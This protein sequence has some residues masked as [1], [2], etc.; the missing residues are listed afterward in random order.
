MYKLA[1]KQRRT[2]LLRN[3]GVR[4]YR[5]EH[6]EN[7]AISRGLQIQ[8]FNNVVSDLL[9]REPLNILCA[10]GKVNGEIVCAKIPERMCA[11]GEPW[12]TLCYWYFPTVLEIGGVNTRE[13]GY[14]GGGT[15]GL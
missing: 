10:T 13:E 6:S 7:A 1:V 5:M 8:C 4:D 15:K 2:K 14:N 12:N 9:S 3:R 11:K